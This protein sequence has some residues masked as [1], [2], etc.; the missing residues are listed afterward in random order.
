MPLQVL[1]QLRCSAS[2]RSRAA[3][4]NERVRVAVI[5]CGNQGKAHMKSLSSLNNVEIVNICDV[6]KDRLAGAVEVSGGASQ[7]PI[8]VRFSTI[9]P[10]DGGYHCDARPLA[11]AGRA[12]GTG[13]R[14]ARL[15]GKALLSQYS[16]RS[17][18]VSGGK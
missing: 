8:S 3:D 15:C 12:V 6:D 1:Q 18:A 7:W 2:S 13:C 16:R 17:V 11:H 14:Q 4:A 10:V 5:G 9:N